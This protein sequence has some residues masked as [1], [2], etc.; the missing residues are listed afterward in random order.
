MLKKGKT[1]GVAAPSTVSSTTV[2]GVLP[3][4]T[5]YATA[6]LTPAIA[7]ST[8]PPPRTSLGKPMEPGEHALAQTL[9][10]RKR[11]NMPPTVPDDAANA[12]RRVGNS[13]VASRP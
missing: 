6:S 5:G 2:Q 9:A 8:T 7:N 12:T 11:E 10:E 13:F 3:Q 1:S 4:Y